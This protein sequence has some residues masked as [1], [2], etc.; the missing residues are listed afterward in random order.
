MLRLR[1]SSSVLLAAMV[2]SC[3][4]PSV[5][6]DAYDP[7]A[8]DAG[9]GPLDDDGQD[10]DP[11]DDPDEGDDEPDASDDDAAEPDVGSSLK[12]AGTKDAGS[13]P[14]PTPD[15]GCPDRDGDSICDAD[16]N[17]PGEPNGAQ[18]D[19]NGNGIGDVCDV[20][21]ETTCNGEPA[22]LPE[23]VDLGLA[24][25]RTV[26]VNGSDGLPNVEPG[27]TI[28]VSAQLT[29]T[30]CGVV[31][32]YRGVSVGVESGEPECAEELYCQNFVPADR[33]IAF[34][35]EAPTEPGLHYVGMSI[36]QARGECGS[37]APLEVRVAAIC[38]KDTDGE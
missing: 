9:E 6:D 33:A 38:V 8:G 22:P 30:A 29:F 17:C 36:G 28:M 10:G 1:F 31:G 20:P 13:Q 15:A 27:E 37:E 11:D 2:L 19:E 18:E 26:R 4:R 25:V 7:T 3:A 5:E 32:G 24:Q 23:V 14:M 21:A 34:E 16:D 12:D 35:V